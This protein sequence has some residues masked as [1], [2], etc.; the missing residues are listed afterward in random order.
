[1]T[2][3]SGIFAGDDPI[4]LAKSWLA[5]AKK[6]ELND[7]IAVSLAT[8]DQCGMP[9]VR[10]VLLKEIEDNAFV[11]YTN[12]ESA[13][14][15]ELISSGKA[16]LNFHWKSLRR[17]VRIRG[18]VETEDGAQADAYYNSRPL[19]SRIGAWASQ[20]SRPLLNR[21]ELENA[22]RENKDALGASP[23]RPPHWGGFRIKPLEMEF[24]ADGPNRLHD[25]FKWEKLDID[26][27][28][29][30]NRLNP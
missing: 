5:E 3:R 18:L 7:A 11:F 8:V 9:N 6:T 12:Y 21:E 24:W 29:T 16:A 30:I 23:E 19:D 10:I 1:M 17:Q 15:Q 27:T 2:D 14:G 20:Q 4:A 25:R 13:K 26:A 28:W 22:V